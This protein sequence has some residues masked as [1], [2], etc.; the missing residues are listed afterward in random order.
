MLASAQT[1][2]GALKVMG[3]WP[4]DSCG[5]PWHQAVLMGVEHAEE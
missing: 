3:A 5:G 1:H 4:T 2:S